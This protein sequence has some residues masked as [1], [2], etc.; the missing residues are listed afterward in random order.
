MNARSKKRSEGF[1]LIEVIVVLVVTAIVGT[2]FFTFLGTSFLKSHVP[3]ENLVRAKDLNQVMENIRADYKP[4]PVW[5]PGHTYAVGDKVMPTAF[6]LSGQRYWYKCTQP[7]TS[8]SIEPNPWTAGTI[9]LD[10]NVQWAYQSNPPLLTL[11][12]LKNKIGVVDTINKK[13]VYDKS[14]HQYGYYVIENK[15]IEFNPATKME[16]DSSNQNIL[17]ITISAKNDSGET[18]AVVTALF[19]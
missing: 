2:I 19:F 10:G 14:T 12:G 5:K 8:S 3:R 16:T 9:P 17:K 4:Y 6:S 18:V 1:T 7:G 11:S 13:Y 15:W